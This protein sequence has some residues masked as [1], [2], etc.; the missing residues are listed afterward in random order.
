MI[1][2]IASQAFSN[3][4]I[5]AVQSGRLM[6][7]KKAVATVADIN[8]VDDLRNTALHYAALQ[9]NSAIVDYLLGSD[10]NAKQRNSQDK[11]PFQLALE[12]QKMTIE[13]V[14][15]VALLLYAT[16][17]I[18]GRDPKGWTAL[19]WAI[20]SKD[21]A[22]IDR[23]LDEGAKLV[24][25]ASLSRLDRRQHAIEIALQ[26]KDSQLQAYLINRYLAAEEDNALKTAVKYN[27]YALVEILIK[28]GF[29]ADERYTRHD[30]EQGY[31]GVNAEYAYYTHGGYYDGH[32]H[33]G[34][35]NMYYG[36]YYDSSSVMNLAIRTKNPRLVTLLLDN[37]LSP[38]GDGGNVTPIQAAIRLGA[39]AT[40]IFKILVVYGANISQ[41]TLKDWNSM[42]LAVASDDPD[43]LNLL[44]TEFLKEKSLDEL[45]TLVR[46][47]YAEVKLK[48]MLE[49]LA[50]HG[51]ELKEHASYLLHKAVINNNNSLLEWL[52]QQGL[53][54]D[55][56]N[57]KGNTLLLEAISRGHEQQVEMLLKRGAN[58]SA[59]TSE[60]ITAIGLNKMNI[61]RIQN[62][63]NAPKEQAYVRIGELLAD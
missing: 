8:A 54:V 20:L 49:T 5:K 25:H 14:K 10:A 51:L 2:V 53:D 57:S 6:E 60:G 50:Q 41:S 17:G 34:H 11:L 40:D 42:M 52:L 23:F 22:L 31:D 4:L 18:E 28:Q 47:W 26:I 27:L 24:R 62:F 35:G 36:D 61:E 43:F 30:D 45:F 32:G 15:T 58:R 46:D 19:Y 13:R 16:K 59:T 9:G 33:D 7:V 48:T 38:D 3:T 1:V 37:G 39:N 29:L 21:R 55:V 56:L 63:L 44:I 12:E